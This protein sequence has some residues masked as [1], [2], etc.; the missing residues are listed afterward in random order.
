MMPSGLC[1]SGSIF[2]KHAEDGWELARHVYGRIGEPGLWDWQS[3]STDVGGFQ[4]WLASQHAALSQYRFSN[5]RK[6]ES[7]DAFSRNGTGSVV[8]SFVNWITATGSFGDLVRAAHR[9]VGQNPTEVF[10]ALYGDM[11]RVHR[12]GRLAKFDFLAL[13]G[14][15]GIA[16][17]TPGSAYIRDNAIGPF[18]GLCMLVTGNRNGPIIRTQADAIYVELGQALTVGMQELEDALCN[19]QKSPGEYRHFRG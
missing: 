9:R 16:P 6:Y 14:K 8:E 5:H 18:L 19:W 17:I 15:L 1:F 10:D 13:L 12:F 4:R 2:G 7:L 3:V 11:R